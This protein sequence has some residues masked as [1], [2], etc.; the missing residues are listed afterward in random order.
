[1]HEA[2]RVII[3]FGRKPNELDNNGVTGD[4]S[5]KFGK[6]TELSNKYLSQQNSFV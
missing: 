3:Y 6:T 4:E 5:N 1:M 2:G